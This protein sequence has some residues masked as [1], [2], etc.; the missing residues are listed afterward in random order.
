[1]TD[2]ESA[3]KQLRAILAGPVARRRRFLL[4]EVRCGRCSE[5]V[6]QV[7]ETLPRVY[8]TTHPQTWQER[9]TEPARDHSRLGHQNFPEDALDDLLAATLA[10]KGK[11]DEIRSWDALVEQCQL[12]SGTWKVPVICRCRRFGVPSGPLVEAV[13]TRSKSSAIS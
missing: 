4:H 5:R 8:V 7:W 3:T 13:E 6:L 2:L 9:S 12:S 1:M 10:R 11:L